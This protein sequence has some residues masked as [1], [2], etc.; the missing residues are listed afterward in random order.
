[1]KIPNPASFGAAGKVSRGTLFKGLKSF[2]KQIKQ[3]ADPKMGSRLFRGAA[4]L[5]ANP[6]TGG[7]MRAVKRNPG[8][9][10]A[11]IIGGAIG[12]ISAYRSKKKAQQIN[13]STPRVRRVK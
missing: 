3:D 8:V 9:A 11:G 4:H 10:S 5:D 1:M 2:G 13:T 7:I 6:V 12:G